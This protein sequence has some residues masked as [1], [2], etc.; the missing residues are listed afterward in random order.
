VVTAEIFLVALSGALVSSLVPLVNAE[1]LL[2]GLA[3][4]SPA[5]APLLVVVMAAGQMVGKSALFLGGARLTRS[6]LE[7]R[8]ARWRLDER[9]GRAGAP[10]IGMSALTG[11][12]PFYLVSV[13]APALGVRFRTFLVM[14]LAGRLLRFAVLVA[15]PRLVVHVARTGGL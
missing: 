1:L 4:A 12:P 2:M 15:L 14:G 3:L 11:L 7:G 5:A 10:L 8:L 9:T 13:A 6:P